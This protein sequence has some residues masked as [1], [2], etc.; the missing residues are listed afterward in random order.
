MTARRG[1]II[2]YTGQGKGKTT[3]AL[4]LALRAWGQGLRV[5]FLQF[6]KGP[7]E[8]GELKAAAKMDGFEIRPLGEGFVR[9]GDEE[10]LRKHRTAAQNAFAV[11]WDAVTRGSYD[12]IVLDEIFYVVKFGFASTDDILHLLARKP[13]T[14]HL[15]LT[16]RDAPAAVIEQADLVTEMREVKH[17]YARGIKA[18]KGIEY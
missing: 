11:A 15:V 17:P 14:V 4:G 5:L 3:A 1:L 9:L 10:A 2:V 12:M 18:Q 16:G 6:L 7:W 13:A 8:T